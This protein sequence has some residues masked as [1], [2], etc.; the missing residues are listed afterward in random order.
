MQLVGE[1]IK[2]PVGKV[3]LNSSAD[4]SRPILTNHRVAQGMALLS[5]QALIALSELCLPDITQHSGAHETLV[6]RLTRRVMASA[7]GG[8]GWQAL[9]PAE[10]CE[11]LRLACRQLSSQAPLR[12]SGRVG[13]LDM[14]RLQGSD[15]G[16]D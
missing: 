9:D 1:T 8:A 13:Q 10:G 11:L 5:Q 6:Q 14:W 7:L 15:R 2:A 16:Y 12:E 3:A 4:P